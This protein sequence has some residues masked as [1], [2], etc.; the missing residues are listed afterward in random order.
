MTRVDAAFTNGR[1]LL[2]GGYRL[3]YYIEISKFFCEMR[4]HD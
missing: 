2:Y 1:Y 4:D 3:L